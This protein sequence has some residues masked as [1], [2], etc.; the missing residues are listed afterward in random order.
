MAIIVLLVLV[1]LAKLCTRKRATV[2]DRFLQAEGDIPSNE[3]S[4]TMGEP[5]IEPN[6]AADEHPRDVARSPLGR[7]YMW[8]ASQ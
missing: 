6:Q 5:L 2:S 4:F 7:L 3:S 8:A 1:V